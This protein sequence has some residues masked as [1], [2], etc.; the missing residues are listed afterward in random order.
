MVILH[1]QF[2]WPFLFR[3]FLFCSAENNS[4]A[5]FERVIFRDSW[6]VN[7]D[8][9][10][11]CSHGSLTLVFAEKKKNNV[12]QRWIISKRNQT[13]MEPGRLHQESRKKIISITTLLQNWKKP[14]KK[15]ELV[16][17]ER[18]K[19]RISTNSNCKVANKIFKKKKLTLT[20]DFVIFLL[21]WTFFNYFF[22]LT[23][24]EIYR[25]IKTQCLNTQF[26]N[27]PRKER[28]LDA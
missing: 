4:N 7:H 13:K 22:Y 5:L 26:L 11:L 28:S 9:F 12:A 24:F 19:I 1:S 10:F 20:S 25:K 21:I 27:V 8:F 17:P 6:C 15:K 2:A 3:L 23:F 16:L 14:F 18:S